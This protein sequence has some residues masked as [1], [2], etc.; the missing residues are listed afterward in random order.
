MIHVQAPPTYKTSRGTVYL[1]DP[2]VA[3]IAKTEFEPT[4]VRSFLEGFEDTFDAEDYVNDFLDPYDPGKTDDGKMTLKMDSGASLVKFAGQLCYMSMGTQR[5]RNADGQKYLDHIKE[6]GHGSV[7]EHANYSFLFWGIDRS[8]THE[9]VRHRAGMAYSQV[10]QRY[11]SGKTLRFVERP[12]YQNDTMLHLL[13]EQ[14]IDVARENYDRVAEMLQNSMPNLKDMPRTDARK[15]VNQTARS[16]LPNETEAPI[17]VTGN[18]RAWRHVIEMR[19]SK[20]AE[21]TIRKLF[22][23]VCSIL[24]EA[25]PL[26]FSDYE[27]E[28]ETLHAV[29]T[30]FRKV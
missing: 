27:P 28:S 21:T 17:V 4:A 2:G 25:S 29:S 3:L 9:L 26:I 20:F 18:A 13:F 15:A 10:S 5:T 16:G 6:S 8:V 11:V 24:K 12:E 1:K 14:R 22:G 19:A 7:L 23:T 30:R